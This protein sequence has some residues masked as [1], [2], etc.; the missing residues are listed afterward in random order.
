MIQRSTKAL[1]DRDWYII[2]HQASIS[3]FPNIFSIS[4]L[5]DDVRI[6]RHCHML[7][8]ISRLKISTKN[9]R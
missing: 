1:G 8:A 9:K 5:D 6:S 2:L 3:V 4:I 7:S